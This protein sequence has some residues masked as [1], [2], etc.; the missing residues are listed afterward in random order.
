MFDLNHDA[1]AKAL[2]F[3]ITLSTCAISR[4]GSTAGLWGGGGGGRSG[5]AHGSWREREGGSGD[6]V[7]GEDREVG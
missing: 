3:E 2:N 5:C 1:I 7:W 4:N 6:E